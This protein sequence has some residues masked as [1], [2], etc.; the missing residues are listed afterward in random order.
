MM[1]PIIE[2]AIK[3]AATLSTDF[4]GTNMPTVRPKISTDNCNISFVSMML[5]FELKGAVRR[6]R[7]NNGLACDVGLRGCIVVRGVKF[8]VT[9]FRAPKG[10]NWEALRVN[11]Y[12]EPKGLL[13]WTIMPVCEPNR[14]TNV[15]NK[16]LFHTATALGTL[17]LFHIFTILSQYLTFE[18]R[19]AHQRILLEWV[20]RL[21]FQKPNKTVA[22]SDRKNPFKN[23][24]SK[25]SFNNKVRGNPRAM[26]NQSITFREKGIE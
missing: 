5:T 8:K 16:P 15:G 17:P 20:R 1:R 21:F 11:T 22:I 24:I 23:Q 14:L 18:L 3:T 4:G 26:I 7:W 10:A 13:G 2:I 25:D 9:A 19:G 12:S 6:H